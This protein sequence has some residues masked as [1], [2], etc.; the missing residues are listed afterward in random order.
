[1][2]KI[3][4]RVFNKRKQDFLGKID[5]SSIGGIDSKIKGLCDKI[6]SFSDVYTTSSCS[7]R[8]LLMIDK[9]KKQQG[10]FLD[11]WHD[12]L[13]LKKFKKALKK[14]TLNK[15]KIKFKQESP[16]VVVC[17]KDFDIAKKILNIGKNSGFKRSGI[18]SVSNKGYMVELMQTEKIEFPVIQNSR[19]LV[20]DE[21]L[22]LVLERTNKN[23]EEGWSRIKGFEERLEGLD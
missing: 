14:N 13:G 9:T 23:L 18:M 19:V 20:D 16:L 3:D 7:G 5:K 17:C 6:N 11:V 2:E 12:K 15:D 22:E 4:E 10:L 21:F 8:I 1:M